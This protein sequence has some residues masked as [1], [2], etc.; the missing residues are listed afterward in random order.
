L[1]EANLDYAFTGAFAVSFYGSPRTTSDVDVMIAIKDKTAK[2]KVVAAL[3]KAGLDV[4]ERTIDE[5]LT[6][7]YNVA[8]VRDKSSMYRIDVIFPDKLEKQRASVM[9]IETFLQTPESLILA[10]LRMIKV[11]V[12]PERAAKDKEDVKGIL[13]FTNVDLDKLKKQ[14]NQEKTL[15]ILK[16]LL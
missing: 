7:G 8:T 15:D 5:A 14:A 10:K 6:S 16:T 4:D 11:T 2:A 3:Q 13:T 9:G 1:D 12:P